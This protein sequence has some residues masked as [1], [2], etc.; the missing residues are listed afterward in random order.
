MSEINSLTIVKNGDYTLSEDSEMKNA[1]ISYLAAEN[2]RDSG[3]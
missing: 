3:M 1:A 2:V